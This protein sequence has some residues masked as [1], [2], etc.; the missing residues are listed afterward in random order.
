MQSA[1]KFFESLYGDLPKAT[2]IY[3]A[4][5]KPIWQNAAADAF[6]DPA[7]AIAQEGL[8]ALQQQRGQAIRKGGILYSLIPQFAEGALY[9]AVQAEYEFEENQ[10]AAIRVLKNASAKLNGYLN[11]I[12]GVAQQIGLESEEGARIGAEVH[13]ILRMSSHLYHL[14]DRSGSKDYLIPIAPDLFLQEFIRAAKELKPQLSLQLLE[15]EPDLFVRMMPENMELILGILVSNAYRFGGGEIALQAKREGEKI[16]ICV[17]DNGPGVQEPERLFEWGYRTP[18]QKGALGL[19][20]SLP[21]AQKL[22]ELQGGSIAYQRSGNQT[23]FKVLLEPADIPVG[24]RLAEWAA[25]PIENSLSQM[26]IELS[27]IL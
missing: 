8:Q 16:A 27:D 4:E 3:D 18:D 14:M 24:A 23:C 2:F 21:T 1:R 25:E 5:M 11:H 22:L 13:R 15:S 19:G 26:R 9:L 7:A 17:F 12:Y 10:K 20:F 6:Q